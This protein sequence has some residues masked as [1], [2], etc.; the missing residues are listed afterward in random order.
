MSL[1]HS[2]AEIGDLSPSPPYTP[3]DL[4]SLLREEWDDYFDRVAENTVM[5]GGSN[6]PM[7]EDNGIKEYLRLAFCEY[8]GIGH[9]SQQ[10]TV[11]ELDS[12][13]YLQ[14]EVTDRENPSDP[15]YLVSS[16]ELEL[17]QFSVEWVIEQ[18]IYKREIFPYTIPFPAGHELIQ[19][20]DTHPALDWLRRGLVNL[21]NHHEGWQHVE[22][23]L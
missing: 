1:R 14:Y 15:G 12:F 7:N 13:P 17:E 3:S 21:G 11:T 10:F 5:E 8:F 20:G 22:F 4:E 6:R 9:D 23:K 16:E 19:S 18:N 2:D